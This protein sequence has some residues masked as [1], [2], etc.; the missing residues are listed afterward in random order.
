MIPT[1][2]PIESLKT[3]PRAI[4]AS[5]GRSPSIYRGSPLEMVRTMASE[6]VPFDLP[7]RY[8][9]LAILSGLK[10]NRGIDIRLPNVCNDEEFAALFVYALLDRGICRP[11]ATDACEDRPQSAVMPAS[12]LADKNSVALPVQKSDFRISDTVRVDRVQN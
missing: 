11:I 3:L 4:W 7:S 1:L 10:R 9:I 5:G 2:V 12:L 8:V 6:M